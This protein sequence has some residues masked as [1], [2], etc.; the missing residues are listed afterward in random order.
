VGVERH[1][2][3]FQRREAVV[4]IQRMEEPQLQ[5]AAPLAGA[6]RHLAASRSFAMVERDRPACRVRFHRHPVGAQKMEFARIA[7]RL[8]QLDIGIAGKQKMAIQGLEERGAGLPLVRLLQ[9]PQQ[10]VFLDLGHAVIEQPGD[11]RSGFG[12]QPHRAVD[13]RVPHEPFARQRGI[14]AARPARLGLRLEGD[15]TA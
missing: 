6:E 1:Q 13:D 11:R 15:E 7:T 9:Q 5:R 14:V 10:R 12:D 3:R 2:S 8:D 4:V